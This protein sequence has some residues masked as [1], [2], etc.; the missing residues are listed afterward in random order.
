MNIGGGHTL[1]TVNTS[2]PYDS[3]DRNRKPDN[4]WLGAISNGAN[5]VNDL[6]TREMRT[7][8]ICA[9]SG[10]YSYP[11]FTQPILT[12][13]ALTKEIGCPTG[14]FL[15]G[16]GV[17]VNVRSAEAYVS[18]TGPFDS[19]IDLDSVRGDGWRGAIG[20]SGPKDGTMRVTAICTAPVAGTIWEYVEQ[21]QLAAQNSAAIPGTAVCDPG[22]FETG[23]GVTHEGALSLKVHSTEPYHDAADTDTKPDDGWTGKLIN[24]TAT[25]PL[26]TTV[27]ICTNSR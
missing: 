23:G 1:T 17:S 19:T 18:M 26:M 21:T 3:R 9:S 5:G 6:A 7:F 12:G 11:T 22:T 25:S 2:A 15:T 14:R 20:L 13:E 4:G 27:A 10:R 16:G 24:T 8:A